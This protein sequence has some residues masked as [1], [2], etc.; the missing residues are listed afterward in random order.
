MIKWSIFLLI[1]F[2]SMTVLAEKPVGFLWYSIE[3][4]HHPIKKTPHHGTPF[5]QLSYTQQDAVLR[6]YTMEALHKARQT[7]KVEDMRVFLSLQDYWLK[8]S[9]R[10]KQLFQ[11]TMLAYPQ[12]DYTV[13]HP[14]SNLGAKITD[15]VREQK[16]EEVIHHA[17]KSHGLLFFYRGKSPYDQKQ[18]PIL[19][20]FCRRFNLSMMSVSVDGVV[21]PELPNSRI[22]EGQA[23][24]LGVRYFPALLL[25][26]PE[27]HQ[28]NPIAYGL[29]TQDVLMERIVQVT[30]QFQGEL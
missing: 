25:V 11:K 16:K 19:V 1:V 2:H 6:F 21:V 3:K 8:E 17:A 26:N 22:D 4:E 15:E 28:V 10:F 30:T 24:R 12:Y 29:T 23:E 20:D 27:T 9:S 7:K 14:T 5:N 18:I 13:T